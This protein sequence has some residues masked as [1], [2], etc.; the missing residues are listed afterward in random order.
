MTSRIMN[1]G[2]LRS[3]EVERVSILGANDDDVWELLLLI[4]VDG[5]FF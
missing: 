4:A 5:V 1:V 2:I 3:M